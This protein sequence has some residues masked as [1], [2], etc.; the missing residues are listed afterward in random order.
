MGAASVPR[1]ASPPLLSGAPL[2]DEDALLARIAELPWLARERRAVIAARSQALAAPQDLWTWFDSVI[3]LAY[4]AAE[5][6]AVRRGLRDARA[7]ATWERYSR[8]ALRALR[9]LPDPRCWSTAHL[10]RVFINQ[11]DRSTSGRPLS[12][13]VQVECAL[14]SLLRILPADWHPPKGSLDLRAVCRLGR[15]AAVGAQSAPVQRQPR[16]EIDDVLDGLEREH[17]A[18][19]SALSL[20]SLRKLAFVLFAVFLPSRACEIA[21]RVR[22]RHA[23][24]AY[25]LTDSASSRPLAAVALDRSV[26]LASLAARRFVISFTLLG[27][28]GDRKKQ[29]VQKHLPHVPGLRFSPALA[30]LALVRRC[31]EDCD[32]SVLPEDGFVFASVRGDRSGDFRSPVLP[33]TITR[34]LQSVTLRYCGVKVGSR[35]WRSESAVWLHLHGRSIEQI[36]LAGGWFRTDTV[37]LHYLRST[38]PEAEQLGELFGSQ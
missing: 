33:K 2:A 23:R 34:L 31:V 24:F 15:A 8:H 20:S 4:P 27:T 6:D 29:G 13:A 35:G 5:H 26:P 7:P 30:V 14:R 36:A 16:F 9:S 28:K 11:I 37:L 1:S 22:F 18:D 12:S 21:Q 17:G 38:V 3:S 19:M 10:V 32:L 25:S